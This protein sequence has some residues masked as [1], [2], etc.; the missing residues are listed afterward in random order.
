MFSD[1]VVINQ[2]VRK[3]VSA[4]LVYGSLATAIAFLVFLVI[5]FENPQ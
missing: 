4:I 5:F 2:K 3:V 1:T